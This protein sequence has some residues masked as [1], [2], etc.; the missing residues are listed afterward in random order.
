M[1]DVSA[2]SVIIS[3]FIAFLLICFALVFL[4]MRHGRFVCD[5]FARRV[6]V[7]YEI[8]GRPYPRL[9]QGLKYIEYLRFL[10]R[11]DYEQIPDPELVAAFSKLR[12]A[13]HRQLMFLLFGFAMLGAIALWYEFVHS[14]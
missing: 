6:P 14:I 5:E 9:F 12:Q 3:V 11:R 1:S 7:Q 2:E 10:S 4:A 13:E 8:L